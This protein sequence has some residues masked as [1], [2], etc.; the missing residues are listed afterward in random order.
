MNTDKNVCLDHQLQKHV[1]VTESKED[2]NFEKKLKFIHKINI[3][4]QYYFL[5]NN[6]GMFSISFNFMNQEISNVGNQ[7]S[8]SSEQ[9]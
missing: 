7:S 3:H 6:V 9:I 5:R 1:P 4:V 2:T 8:I